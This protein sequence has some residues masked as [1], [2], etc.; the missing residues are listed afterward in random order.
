ME[1]PGLTDIPSGGRTFAA[2]QMGTHRMVPDPRTS[3]ADPTLRAH[4]VPNLY[5]VGGGDFVTASASLPTLTG[6]ELCQG[7]RKVGTGHI[8]SLSVGSFGVNR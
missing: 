5:L 8:R 4:D 3:V 7:L 6:L 1:T 2:H